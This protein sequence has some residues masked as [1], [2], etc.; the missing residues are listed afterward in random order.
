MARICV[1]SITTNE[2]FRTTREKAKE[3]VSN[4][5]HAYT[6]RT[7]WRKAGRIQH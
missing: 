1:K 6:T 3:L 7:E 4:G 5:T 2:I